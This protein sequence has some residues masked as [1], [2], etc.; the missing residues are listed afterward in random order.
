MTGDKKQLPGGVLSA[1]LSDINTAFETGNGIDVPCGD[2][3]ACCKSSQFIHVEHTETETLSRIPRDLLFPAPGEPP[4]NML[5]GYDEH[6]CCPMLVNEKCS[7]YLHR[8]KTC[9]SYDCRVFPA[10]GIENDEIES[11]LIAHQVKRW[12]F[13]YKANSD[14]DLH[15]AIQAT[16]DFLRLHPECFAGHSPSNSTHLA[17]MAIRSH[18]VFLKLHKDQKNTGQRPEDRE[19][20]AA[21]I[22]ESR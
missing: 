9:R 17:A 13:T 8:P 19:I 1:W 15:T 14:K 7:I 22:A 11:P 2:C 20:V 10:S 6:G 5:M 16:A 12:T 18:K 4:G 21:I 3:T